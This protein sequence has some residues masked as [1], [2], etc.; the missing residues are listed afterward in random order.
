MDSLPPELLGLVMDRLRPVHLVRLMAASRKLH[1][2]GRRQRQW[3]A[4]RVRWGLD[5][6]KARARALRSDFDI[7]TRFLARACRLCMAAP[8]GA[9]GHCRPCRASGPVVAL[10]HAKAT[11]DSDNQWVAALE[12]SLDSARARLAV[13]G[14][15][16]E[17][18]QRRVT[19]S[20]QR[21]VQR[22]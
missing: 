3:T 17:A 11:W 8:A 5:P 7:A 16:L 20:R 21:A 14:E 13:Q 18:A 10:E 22:L 15:R 12:N 1:Q 19:R 6:P 9:G 2:A 4:L